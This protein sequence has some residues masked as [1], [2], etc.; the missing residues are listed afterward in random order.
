[1]LIGLSLHPFPSLAGAGSAL[2]G[3]IKMAGSALMLWLVALFKPTDPMMLMIA[4]FIL[5]LISLILR[6]SILASKPILT[7][8]AHI[9]K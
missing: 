8:P 4:I 6:T 9:E 2:Q 7:V 5:T 1:L 3:T